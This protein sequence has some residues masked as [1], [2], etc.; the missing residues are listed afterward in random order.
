M[1]KT[2]RGDVSGLVDDAEIDVVEGSFQRSGVWSDHERTP[3]ART[4]ETSVP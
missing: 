4:S 1:P 3:L 2:M